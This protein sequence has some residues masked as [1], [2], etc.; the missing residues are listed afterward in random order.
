MH[1][2]QAILDVMRSWVGCHEGDATHKHIIDTY[3]SH[4]PLAVGYKVKYTDD[5]CATTV[6]AAA[7][8]CGYTDII[9]TECG[10]ERMV[11]LAIKMGIWIEDDSYV[12]M[13]ADVIMYDWDDSGKGDNRGWSDH[14]G[15]V[16]EVK[17]GF[18]TAI[19][20][21][22]S[23]GVNRRKILL[24]GKYIRGFIAPKYD[25][26]PAS[27]PVQTPPPVQSTLKKYVYG[28]DLSENQ[29]AVDFSKVKNA[30]YEFVILRSI[31]R[32]GTTDPKFSQYLANAKKAGL[33]VEGVYKLSYAMNPPEA[34]NEAVKVVQLLNSSNCR[35]V[36]IWLDLE[37]Y[38]GQQVLGKVAIEAIARGFLDYC[39][40][41]GFKVGIY[42]NLDWWNNHISDYL[43]KKYR[44]WIARYG[45]NTGKLDEAYRPNIPMEMWQFTSHGQVDGVKALPKNY[46]DINVKC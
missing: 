40:A 24:N 28:I 12:P 33:K 18:I 15:Y 1:S 36:T 38:G 14:T 9:P 2:R 45:K 32:N 44:F 6:S 8:E 39:E 42:C 30:G 37:N 34:F 41:S 11:K 5:W 35:D 31:K 16:E 17:D 7:I 20:G 26:V 4:K 27:Q 3:N 25:D 19:E 10:C 43:K 23:D 22:K 21:N 29:T 46:V 13:P